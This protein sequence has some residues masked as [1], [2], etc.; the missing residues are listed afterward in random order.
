MIP[1]K[2]WVMSIAIGAFE[3]MDRLPDF[4]EMVA[5]PAILVPQKIPVH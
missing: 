5:H 1:L 4:D 3:D 2:K